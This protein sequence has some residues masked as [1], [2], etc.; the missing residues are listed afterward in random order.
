REGAARL[1]VA[2]VRKDDRLLR[3][4]RMPARHRVA[5]LAALALAPG[6]PEGRGRGE[7]DVVRAVLEQIREL[8]EPRHAQHLLEADQVR[9]EAIDPA[10]D[11]LRPLGPGP[12]VVPEVQREDREGS[13]GPPL[14][15]GSLCAL[16]ARGS[17]P[18]TCGSLCALRACGST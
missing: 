5:E 16:R 3:R 7:G 6:A 15:C 10:A 4:D 11:A 12:R 9:G 14:A 2:R 1:A 8:V 18:P 13:R 17:T